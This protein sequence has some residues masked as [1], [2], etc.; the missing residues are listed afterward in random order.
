MTSAHRVSQVNS[1]TFAVRVLPQAEGHRCSGQHTGR[2]RSCPAGAS[3]CS[4]ALTSAALLPVPVVVPPPAGQ[5]R[6][7]AAAVLQV[8]Q[9]SRGEVVILHRR[10]DA[11]PGFLLGQN[12]LPGHPGGGHDRVAVGVPRR[13]VTGGPGRAGLEHPAAGGQAPRPS[14]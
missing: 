13:T 12:A 11:A 14:G 5:S 9:P 2:G 10:V 6:P 3:S 7:R 8:G 1:S 4:P